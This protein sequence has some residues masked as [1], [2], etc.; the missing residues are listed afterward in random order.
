M[1][2]GEEPDDAVD[3]LARR[4]IGAAIEVHK[5][6][7]PGFL[8]SVYENAMSVELVLRGIP[9]VQQHPISLT[10]KGR[11]VG[12]SKLDFLVANTL[13]LELKAVNMLNNLHSAQVISHL[14]ATHLKLGLL[15]NFNVPLLKNGLKRIIL[16]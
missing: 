12:L 15:I 13:V 14:R 4:V 7:G 9:F 2:R 5:E 3:A 16:S 11:D 8:E 10:Y 1:Q 6:I